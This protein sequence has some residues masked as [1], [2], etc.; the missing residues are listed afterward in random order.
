MTDKKTI[1][2]YDARA[3]DYERRFSSA[4]PDAH[5]SAFLKL[6]PTGASVVDLGCGTGSATRHLVAAGH[7]VTAIDASEEMLALAREQADAEFLLGTFDALS[8]MEDLDG[9]WANFSLL[10]LPRSEMAPHITMIWNALRGGGIFHLGLK[11]GTGEGRDALGRFYSYYSA[12]EI[13]AMLTGAGFEILSTSEG[14][15]PGLDGTVAPWV[16]VLAQKPV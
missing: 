6:L 12:D 9:V 11:S 3:G 5:L 8:D 1:S 15:D 7:E 13:D 10:H 2:V 4:A 14:K 16:I